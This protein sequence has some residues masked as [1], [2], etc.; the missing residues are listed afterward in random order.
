MVAEA[1]A[2]PDKIDVKVAERFPW[3]SGDITITPAQSAQSAQLRRAG[4]LDAG[5]IRIAFRQSPQVALP[6]SKVLV[7]ASVDFWM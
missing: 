1:A 2:D 4:L 3:K 6:G 7:E 5:P